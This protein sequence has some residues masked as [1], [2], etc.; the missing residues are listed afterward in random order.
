LPQGTIVNCVLF[1]IKIN[2]PLH[3]MRVCAYLHTDNLTLWA[4]SNK[5]VNLDGLLN[6]ALASLTTWT[7]S[8]TNVG[9]EKAFNPRPAQPYMWRGQHWQNMACIQQHEIQYT[10]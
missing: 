6:Q 10:E 9:M 3:A 8:K 2:G 7:D 5:T 1:N 4:T